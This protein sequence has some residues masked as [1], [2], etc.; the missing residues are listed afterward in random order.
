MIRSVLNNL[1]LDVLNH[2]LQG[3]F[4]HSLCYQASRYVA[5]PLSCLVGLLCFEVQRFFVIS[6]HSLLLLSMIYLILSLSW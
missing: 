3:P 5:S 1:E 4:I 2:R 6:A